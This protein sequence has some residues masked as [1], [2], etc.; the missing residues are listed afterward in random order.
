[1]D[2]STKVL[3]VTGV[4]MVLA[5]IAGILFGIGL[6]VINGYLMREFSGGQFASMLSFMMSWAAVISI[7]SSLLELFA[8]IYGFRNANDPARALGCVF[9]GIFVIICSIFCLGVNS[10]NVLVNVI[11]GIVIPGIFVA[12]AVMK[13]RAPGEK[14]PDVPQA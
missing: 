13:V 3:K 4:F 5:G 9:L 6:F 12:G 2:T 11:A 8:G 7:G 14:T 1:M 10:G